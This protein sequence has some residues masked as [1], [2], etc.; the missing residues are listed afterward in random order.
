MA[1]IV[2]REFYETEREDDHEGERFQ[3]HHHYSTPS[4]HYPQ[5]QDQDS[6][7]SYR[8]GEVGGVE[9][10]EEEQ[11]EEEEYIFTTSPS[12][13]EKSTAMISLFDMRNDAAFCDVAFLVHGCLF[14]AHKVIVRYGNK[15]F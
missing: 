12:E 2:G 4:H 11:E 14:R 13:N 8:E 15:S 9:Q 6:H 3:S 7:D 10:E 1:R 5:Y